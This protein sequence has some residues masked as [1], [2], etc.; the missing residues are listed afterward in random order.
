MYSVYSMANDLRD[1][2]LEGPKI[3]GKMYLEEIK[4]TD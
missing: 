2:S 4:N 1:H 3:D